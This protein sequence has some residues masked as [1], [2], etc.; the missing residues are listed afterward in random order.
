MTGFAASTIGGCRLG[1]ASSGVPSTMGI[2]LGNSGCE[3][4]ITLRITLRFLRARGG[5][6]G[7]SFAG[8]E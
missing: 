5:S 8:T 7:Y 3:S 1:D 2:D 4:S 6:W